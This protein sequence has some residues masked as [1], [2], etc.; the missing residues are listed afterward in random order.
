VTLVVAV[1][2]GQDGKG[3]SVVPSSAAS[4]ALEDYTIILPDE[5]PPYWSQAPD[6]L[7]VPASFA[8][9]RSGPK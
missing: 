8:P 7:L 1:P 9:G 4:G 6:R 2:A 3:W 5:L